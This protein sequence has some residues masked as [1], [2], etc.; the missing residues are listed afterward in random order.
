MVAVSGEVYIVKFYEF[1]LSSSY[2]SAFYNFS[3]MSTDYFHSRARKRVCVNPLAFP[4][5][6]PGFGRGGGGPTGR[7]HTAG[8]SGSWRGRLAWQ[9]SEGASPTAGTA[10]GGLQGL[11]EAQR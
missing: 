8:A 3:T 9:S 1:L 7:G 10:G 2:F 11:P 6:A 4:C 5:R